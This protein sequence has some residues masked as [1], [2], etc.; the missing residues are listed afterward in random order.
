MPTSISSPPY[1]SWNW[2]AQLFHH[3]LASSSM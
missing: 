2:S 1:S 3:S